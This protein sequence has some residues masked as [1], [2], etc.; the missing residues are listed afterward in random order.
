MRRV[1]GQNQDLH[2][3]NV[4]AGRFTGRPGADVV[5]HQQNSLYLYTGQWDTLAPTWVRT[6]P[7]PVWDAYRPGDRFLVGDFDGD[8]KQ[9]LFVYN[10]TDWS[11]PYFAMLRST[12]Q[13]SEACAGSTRFCPAGARCG[14]TI[15]SSWPTLM[16][17]A[18]TISSCST[19]RTGAWAICSFS[20]HRQRPA[21][22]P[23]LR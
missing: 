21:L 18:R 4:Y 10:F 7:D 23:P 16:A 14:R 8:G 5:V 11:M 19:A 6:M 1:A 22:G 15:S 20:A 2:Y 13:G 3:R 12:G 9:D 17:T